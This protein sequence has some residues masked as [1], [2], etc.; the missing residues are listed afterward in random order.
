MKFLFFQRK[1]VNV[2]F[3]RCDISREVNLFSVNV[4]KMKS[5]LLASNY[6]LVS[7]KKQLT[8]EQSGVVYFQVI[9]AH[10]QW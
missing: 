10:F 2:N 1:E 8:I 7:S 5:I 3:E 9:L 4:L 6:S